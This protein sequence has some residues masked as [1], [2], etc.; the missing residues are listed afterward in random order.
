MIVEPFL[1]IL[2]VMT[3]VDTSMVPPLLST[4]TFLSGAAASP[5]A[6]VSLPDPELTAC[7]DHLRDPSGQY[8]MGQDCTGTALPS[9]SV[10]AKVWSGW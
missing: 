1:P 7:A 6:R 10:S 5:A 9:T 4:V 2:A 3:P 8:A